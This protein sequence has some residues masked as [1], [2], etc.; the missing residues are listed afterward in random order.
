MVNRRNDSRTRVADTLLMAKARLAFG[1]TRA[2]PL[3]PWAMLAH[4]IG[5]LSVAH[6]VDLDAVRAR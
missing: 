4:A 6:E 1:G 3:G 2:R 5:A